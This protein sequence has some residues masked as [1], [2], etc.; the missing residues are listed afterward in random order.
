MSDYKLT[1]AYPNLIKLNILTNSCSVETNTE[2]LLK[3]K[4]NKSP[5]FLF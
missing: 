1:D 4:K 5:Y 3:L 2:S